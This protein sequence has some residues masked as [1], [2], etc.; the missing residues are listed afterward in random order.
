MNKSVRS[1]KRGQLKEKRRKAR[2]RRR[3]LFV[4]LCFILALVIAGVLIY[5]SLAPERVVKI[6]PITRPNEQGLS[7]GD[8]NAPVKVVELA[9]FQC[10]GCKLFSDEYESA[11]VSE[12]V[13]T[14]KVYF[15]Y[16]TFSFLDKRDTRDHPLK[17]SHA[18]AEAAYCA[19]DQGKFWEYHDLLYANQTGEN[20][21]D[22]TDRRLTAF[23]Q[24]L[25]LD[26]NKFGDCY[27]SGK[28]KQK[29]I[30]DYTVSLSDNLEQTP[31][32]LVNGKLVILKDLNKTIDSALAWSQSSP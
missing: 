18:A 19:S 30:D 6:T 2:N 32:F 7:I 5:P 24:V 14:G 16:R 26:M 8:P 15:T 17:E 31:S 21:G 3:T 13:E 20:I 11:F 28:Y 27:T 25:G 12:Y 9:D 10:P 23:A 22:F 29:V 4:G 1:G